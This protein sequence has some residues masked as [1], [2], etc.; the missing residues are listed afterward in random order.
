[1]LAETGM[2]AE[3]VSP[4]FGTRATEDTG[5]RRVHGLLADGE[6]HK[7]ANDDVLTGRGGELVA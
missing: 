3:R 7:A 1:V 6:A 2:R 5:Q 4:G